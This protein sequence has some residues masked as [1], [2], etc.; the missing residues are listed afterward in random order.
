[1]ERAQRALQQHGLSLRARAT[2]M[3]VYDDVASFAAAT[4]QTEPAL[5]AWTTWTTVHLLHPRLWGDDSDQTRT[6]RITHELCHAALLHRFHDEQAARAARVPRFF[7]E[8]ACSVIAAQRRL[9]LADVLARAH[10]G[11]PLTVDAFEQDP[12]MAYGAAHALAALLVEQ[13]GPLV[14]ATVM[15]TAAKDGTAGCVER[16]L[17]ALTGATDVARLW[18]GVV[19]S[20]HPAN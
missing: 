19:D 7:T 14:F 6:E 1:M 9:P 18:Q 15:T 4:G 17:L 5:R 13:H 3:V 16:A 8:G 10:D 11:L 2:S 20:A 12:D